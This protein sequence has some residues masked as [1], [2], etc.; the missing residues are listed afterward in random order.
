MSD[1][2]FD[3]IADGVWYHRAKYRFGAL[4]FPHAVTVIRRRDGGLIIHAP[5]KLDDAIIDALKSLGEVSA[6]VWPS[7]W[8]DLY[9]HQWADAYPE[10]LL[11]AAPD[12]RHVVAGRPNSRILA[13]GVAIDADVEVIAVDGL[14]VWLDEYVFF[15]KPSKTLIVADL[16]VNVRPDLPFPTNAFFALMGARSGPFVPWFYRTV[17]RDKRGLREQLDRIASLDFERLIV[18]H[19]DNILS[20]ARSVFINAVDRLFR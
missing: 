14:N 10:A 1:S 5:A 2:M 12:L 15:H 11:F 18:G 3:Y 13:D 17:A 6:I 20:D 7:W 9:L 19:G 4:E 16:V 8:H